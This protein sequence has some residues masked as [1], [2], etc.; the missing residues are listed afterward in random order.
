MSTEGRNMAPFMFYWHE[1]AMIPRNISRKL[2][3]RTFV[4][5]ATYPLVVQ[6]PRS[7]A[8]HNHYFAAIE[9]GW[10]NLG[11]QIA[12]EFPTAE[13]LRKHALIAAGFADKRS[14]VCASKAEAVRTAAF[15]RPMDEYAVVTATHAV[16]TIYTA[17]S[18][19]VRAMGR[20]HFEDSKRA[21]LDVIAAMVGVEPE[22]LSSNAGEAA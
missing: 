22:A 15:V 19:S 5:G 17:K 1:G 10:H 6:E 3:D 14:L 9:K 4:E 11:E 8:S 2:C 16:V 20:K 18:Q 12:G 7:R 21:V 13:H